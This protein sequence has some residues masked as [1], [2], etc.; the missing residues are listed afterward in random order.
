M[1][2]REKQSERPHDLQ[3]RA[4]KSAV[5]REEMGVGRWQK[6]MGLHWSN[7]Y[8]ETIPRHMHIFA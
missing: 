5:L 7:M 4:A 2:E 8:V 6:L 1:I 3:G